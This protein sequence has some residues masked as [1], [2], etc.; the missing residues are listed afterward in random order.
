MSWCPEKDTAA[1]RASPGRSFV[2]GGGEEHPKFLLQWGIE[3]WGRLWGGTRVLVHFGGALCQPCVLVGKAGG[4]QPHI[5]MPTCWH[6]CIGLLP[7]PGCLKTPQ[8]WWHTGTLCR[9]GFFLGGRCVLPALG[10]LAGARVVP[11]AAVTYGQA[12]L[13][14]HCLAFI[15]SCTAVRPRGG[16]EMGAPQGMGSKQGHGTG[17]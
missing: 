8:G 7:L 17:E 16:P 4:R 11:Q 15:E 13:Q 2:P 10:P 3:I 12:D 1:G 5:H 9:V 14:Q 6:P